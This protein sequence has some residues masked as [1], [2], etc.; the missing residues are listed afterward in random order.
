MNEST[1]RRCCQPGPMIAWRDAVVTTAV[2]LL[3]QRTIESEG[4]KVSYDC[5]GVTRAIF[6]QHG[7]DLYQ[8]RLVTKQANGVRYIY[9]HVREFGHLHD[10]PVVSPGDLVFFDN[11][12]DFNGDGM[13]NDPLTHVGVVE[14]IE[15]DGTVVFISRVAGAV[16]RYRMNL[17]HPRRHRTDD[18]RVVN[19]YLRRKRAGDVEG[20]NYL[21]GEL[22]AGFGT[23][24]RK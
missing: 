14:T 1:P 5:A 21:S 8:S 11:T 12:W 7:V 9:Q 20:T 24:Y 22:F 2:G 16:E 10:G 15:H 19:D 4:R 6:L 17:A 3:G 18:G 23:P 13:A